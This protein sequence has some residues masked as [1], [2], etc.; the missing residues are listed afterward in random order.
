MFPKL[1]GP[2]MDWTVC[3]GLVLRSLA[4]NHPVL[5]EEQTTGVPGQ[6]E[7]GSMEL[8]SRV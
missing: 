2:G 3:D 8:G 6:E 7:G 5:T 4:G 1:L